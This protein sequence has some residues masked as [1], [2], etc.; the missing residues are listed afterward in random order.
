VAVIR[1]ASDADDIVDDTFGIAEEES[2]MFA[3][4]AL[5]ATDPRISTRQKPDI[6]KT[7]FI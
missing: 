1:V 3:R 4:S 2:N 7:K 5:V 6:H